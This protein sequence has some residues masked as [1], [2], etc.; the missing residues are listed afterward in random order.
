MD[1]LSGLV[2]D[3]YDDPEGA[4]L[5]EVFP[6]RGSVPGIVK[7]A[8]ALTSDERNK[9]PDEAYALVLVNGDV[10]MRKF[11]TIDEGN[12]ALSVE[13]FLKTAHKLPEEAQK[14]AAHN[15]CCAC[16]WYGLEAP[17][18]LQKIAALPRYLANLRKS[19][20]SSKQIREAGP[21][22]RD[23]LRTYT[24]GQRA[25]QH[26]AK[27]ES[28]L[29]IK[30]IR[31][32]ILKKHAPET[33]EKDIWDIKHRGISKKELN[34]WHNEGIKEPTKLRNVEQYRLRKEGTAAQEVVVRRNPKVRE[35]Q[36]EA[37]KSKGIEA[38]TKT[39]SSLTKEALGLKP[40]LAIGA[41][42]GTLGGAYEYNKL[43]NKTKGDVTTKVAQLDELAEQMGKLA[44]LLDDAAILALRIKA[45]REIEHKQKHAFGLM[46]AGITALMAPGAVREAKKNLDVTKQMGGQV[47]TPGQVK[48]YRQQVGMV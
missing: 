21:Y 33:F 11:A 14:V 42:I 23:K 43:K 3:F 39:A 20:M 36:L 1:K 12:T 16:D 30:D 10:E 28:E 15:L 2:L 48:N 31:Y 47:V 22:I 46:A 37:L 29:A 6:T 44:P 32:G 8:H 25:A 34:K 24:L 41:T 38:P 19:D 13:Y 7:E 27:G 35:R 4:I 17:E 9:L 45:Q 5:R 18:E 40:T 26:H